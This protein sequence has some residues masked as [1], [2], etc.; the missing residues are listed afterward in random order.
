MAWDDMEEQSKKKQDNNKHKNEKR[1]RCGG[2][3]NIRVDGWA[4]GF[5]TVQV[6]VML[7]LQPAGL[8]YR[9]CL[10]LMGF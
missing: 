3:G 6:I 9:S 5:I 1:D 2:A 4:G 8:A 7:N 10:F